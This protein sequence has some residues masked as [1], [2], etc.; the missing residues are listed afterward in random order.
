MR[1]YGSA[2]V[3]S[4]FS[5]AMGIFMGLINVGT[6]WAMWDFLMGGLNLGVA[7]VAICLAFLE[8]RS[9]TLRR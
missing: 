1:Y 8:K 2:I 6:K 5:G 9:E 4:L 3:I 7:T